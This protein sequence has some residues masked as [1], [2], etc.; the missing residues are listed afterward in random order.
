MA[1]LWAIFILV[2]CCMPT[3]T[4]E[5][6]RKLFF[7]GFD[8]LVHLLFFFVLTVLLFYGKIKQQPRQGCSVIFIVKII[9]LTALLGGGIE[10]L[11][12]KIFTY[13]SGE[14]WDFFSDMLGVI[15]AV[16]SYVALHSNTKGKARKL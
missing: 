15:M 16:F 10:F 3:G 9:V 2:A 6:E 14:W 13:R 1:L 4:A 12:W 8:K 5:C 11:Q 7:E